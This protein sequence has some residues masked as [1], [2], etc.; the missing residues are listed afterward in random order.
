[1]A[2]KLDTEIDRIRKLLL[3][4]LD[5]NR[6][7]IRELER[8]AR[9]TQGLFRTPLGG[10]MRLSYRHVLEMVDAVGLPW[11]TFFRA[12]YPLPGETAPS[13]ELGKPL[14]NPPASE[15][16]APAPEVQAS[17][18]E[19][20]SSEGRRLIITLCRELIRLGHLDVQELFE[21]D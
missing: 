20:A 9:V 21:E 12:A 3:K 17:A 5:A 11:T 19:A 18:S 1:M 6:Y 4:T 8:K 16:L 2:D 14:P 7:S 15:P 13:L 10:D